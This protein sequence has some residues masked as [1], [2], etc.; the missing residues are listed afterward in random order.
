M[1]SLVAIRKRKENNEYYEIRIE[2]TDFR[3]DIKGILI[4]LCKE[5]QLKLCHDDYA[6]KIQ[7]KK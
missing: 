6:I 2:L 4:D 7:F 3:K 5:Q 1:D